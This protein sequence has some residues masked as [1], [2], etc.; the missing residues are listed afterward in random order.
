MPLRDP[1]NSIFLSAMHY[2]LK[3][4]GNWVGAALQSEHEHADERVQR[5]IK[6]NVNAIGSGN[7]TGIASTG[8]IG[9]FVESLATDS[10]VVAIQNQ[11]GF[12]R[13]PLNT[14]VAVST[15]NSTAVLHN[16]GAAIPLTRLTINDNVLTPFWV[17]LLL[18]VTDELIRQGGTAAETLIN[19][20]VRKGVGLI[21]NS[22]AFAKLVDGSTTIIASNGSDSAGDFRTAI[23]LGTAR[24]LR[25]RFDWGPAFF[26]TAPPTR[27]HRSGP[28][29]GRSQ[30]PFHYP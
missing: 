9:A 20:E 10:S 19:N 12:V 5:L 3:S 30:K 16:E 6:A 1:A 17:S 14:H 18:V 28:G 25:L 22:E 23:H 26:A 8:A 21:I 15:T 27:A 29:D 11:G 24:A 13:P 2:Y 4:R 7:F